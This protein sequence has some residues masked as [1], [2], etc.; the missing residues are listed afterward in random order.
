MARPSP[1]GLDISFWMRSFRSD[2]GPRASKSVMTLLQRARKD[3]RRFLNPVETKVGGFSTI[4][5][6]LPL[7]LKNR[8][9]SEPKQPLGPFFTD[10]KLYATP[11]ESGLRVTWFGHSSLL[12]EIDGL[13]VLVDPVWEERASPFQWMGPKRFF[14]PTLRLEDLPA[15]DVILVSHDHYDHFGANTLRRLA[16]LPSTSGAAW[17]TSLGVMKRL[18]GLKV[19]P[20]RIT[21]LDWTQSVEIQGSVQGES[22]KVTAWPTRHFSGRGVA[23]R[24]STLWSSFVLEGTKHRVYFGSDS[25]WWEGFPEIASHYERFDLTMLEIGAFHPLWQE[26]HLG[27][28]NAAKAYQAMGGPAKAGLFMPIHW[29]LFNLALHG[30]R[31]PI[32][33]VVELSEQDPAN[34]R[35]W[36]PEPGRPTEIQQG[37]VHETRWWMEYK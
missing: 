14:A 13:R 25:G 15:I 12:I 26:I 4:F 18:E 32:Q 30:W 2:L 27:P 6:V 22:L 8:E 17:I 24:F 19:N 33:R 35:L 10:F 3:G 9:E 37:E 7:Y 29:G 36:L 34:F 5:K 28:D 1:K 11:P 20:K 16:E 31:Q 21:E 23:D